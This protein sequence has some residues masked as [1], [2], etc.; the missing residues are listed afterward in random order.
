MPLAPEA[1]LGVGRQ[2]GRLR[3]PR[4]PR[5][6]PGGPGGVYGV[7]W[8]WWTFHPEKKTMNKRWMSLGACSSRPSLRRTGF[9]IRFSESKRG[10]VPQHPFG[11][12]R[13]IPEPLNQAKGSRTMWVSFVM[14]YFSLSICTE[15]AQ[16]SHVHMFD[17]G[18]S[19]PAFGHCLRPSSADELPPE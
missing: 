11:R 1:L 17:F 10:H 6:R 16:S 19:R 15:W 2:F 5:L 13:G 7:R 18:R 3:P 4:R 9:C 12:L 8:S 14:G